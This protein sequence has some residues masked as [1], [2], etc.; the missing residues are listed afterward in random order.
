MVIAWLILMGLVAAPL[1]MFA[2][3]A[4]GIIVASAYGYRRGAR[5][6]LSLIPRWCGN[7]Q[8]TDLSNP[9][10]SNA[11]QTKSLLA[12]DSRDKVLPGL[13]A[14]AIVCEPLI[15]GWRGVSCVR[16]AGFR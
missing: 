1:L 11:T 6:A 8:S 4:G 2:C 12:Q 9:D 13:L 16:G 7:R 10:V 14:T 3:F 15:A 5:V